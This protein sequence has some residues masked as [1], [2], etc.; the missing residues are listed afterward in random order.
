MIY[1]PL[2]HMQQTFISQNSN[3][4]VAV[5]SELSWAH[6]LKVQYRVRDNENHTGGFF[7][8]E[9]FF[10]FPPQMSLSWENSSL[11][12]TAALSVRA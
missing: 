11:R 7:F 8:D 9:G 2:H 6:K 4:C 10:C 3:I 1:I 5:R 12:A